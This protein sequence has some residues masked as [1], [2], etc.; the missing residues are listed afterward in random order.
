M[1]DAL[2]HEEWELLDRIVGETIEPVEPPPSVRASILKAI[3]A[4]PGPHE[5]RTIRAAEG[6]WT[7]IAPGVRM[8]SLDKR[9]D[10]RTFLVE[11]EPDATLPEHGHEGG[12][13]TFVVRGSCRIGALALNT[14]DFHHADAGAHHGD[15]VAS[16][17]GCVLLLTVDVPHVA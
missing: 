2:T 17:D 4:V 15:V 10:R 16:E 14:G 11:L 9:P 12:E 8:K 5:S 13:N 6:K 7:V 3:R 1:S